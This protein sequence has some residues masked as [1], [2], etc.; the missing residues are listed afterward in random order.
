MRLATVQISCLS[1]ARTSARFRLSLK[2]QQTKES[3][4]IELIPAPNESLFISN[5][6]AHRYRVRVNGKASTKVKDVT[7]TEVFNRLRR[8]LVARAAKPHGAERN[9]RPTSDR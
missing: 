1:M 5:P 8:W 9:P 6:A 3:L 2:D 4:K 7:L